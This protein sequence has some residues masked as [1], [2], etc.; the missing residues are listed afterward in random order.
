MASLVWDKSKPDFLRASILS[1]AII[2]RQP[3]DVEMLLAFSSSRQVIRNFGSPRIDTG[4]KLTGRQATFL[5]GCPEVR[6][7]PIM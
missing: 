2:G 1:L 6:R 4:S 5:A 7:V 3:R